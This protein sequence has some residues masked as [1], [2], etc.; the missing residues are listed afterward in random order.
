[1]TMGAFAGGMEKGYALGR[2]GKVFSGA[3]AMGFMTGAA[4]R[5]GVE[6]ARFGG[7]ATKFAASA[8]ADFAGGVGRVGR[9]AGRFAMNDPGKAITNT[10]LAGAAGL[11]VAS[12]PKIVRAGRWRPGG[13]E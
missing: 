12:L 13:E 3:G 11:G 2:K 7:K 4:G 10:A 9:K 8:G 5:A 6:T 1:M